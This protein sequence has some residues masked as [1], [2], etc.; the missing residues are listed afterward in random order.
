MV[1]MAQSV[2]NWRRNARTLTWIARIH[3]HTYTLINTV[4]TTL[5]EAPA[6]ILQTL[7]PKLELS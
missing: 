1:T 5:C 6:Q 4:T 2:E 7:E 3:S